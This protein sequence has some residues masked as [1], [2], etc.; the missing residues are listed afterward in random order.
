MTVKWHVQT[1]S[2]GCRA[3]T[4]IGSRSCKTAHPISF[5]ALVLPDIRTMTKA[6]EN[7]FSTMD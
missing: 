1:G 4:A 7:L 2:D 6:N 5:R 3:G